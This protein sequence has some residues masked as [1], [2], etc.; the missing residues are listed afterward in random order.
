MNTRETSNRRAARHPWFH[1]PRQRAHHR[2]AHRLRGEDVVGCHL[3]GSARGVGQLKLVDI[4]TRGLALLSPRPVRPGEHLRLQLTNRTGL[5]A[6]AV[7]FRAVRCAPS[8]ATFLIA[9]LFLQPLPADVYR[10]LLA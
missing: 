5:F 1:R 9:G 8:E 6:H 7:E 4:S 3:Q 2:Q 10:Q